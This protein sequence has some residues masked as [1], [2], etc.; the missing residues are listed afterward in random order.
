MEP[1]PLPPCERELLTVNRLIGNNAL[2]STLSSYTTSRTC[3]LSSNSRR[4]VGNCVFVLKSVSSDATTLKAVWCGP[5]TV[6]TALPSSFLVFQA[7][8]RIW[9]SQ[10]R[11]DPRVVSNSFNS[12]GSFALRIDFN[13]ASSSSSIRRSSRYLS[14]FMFNCTHSSANRSFF[15]AISAG[16]SLT[17][18]TFASSSSARLLRLSTVSSSNGVR[19]LGSFIDVSTPCQTSASS[20]S[21]LNVRDL[22]LADP[23]R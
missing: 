15:L 21:A 23:S 16:C 12:A 2:I 22:R 3:N 5:A 9:F 1:I 19:L 13:C 7:I 8:A 6:L 20:E 4:L 11:G 17:D 14:A 10:K 18:L